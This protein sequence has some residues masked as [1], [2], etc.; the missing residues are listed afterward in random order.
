M[1]GTSP[2]AV[3]VALAALLAAESPAMDGV[4]IFTYTATA[5]DITTRDYLVLG[6][7]RGTDTPHGMGG[8]QLSTYTIECEGLVHL[9]GSDATADRAW[10]ILNTVADIAASQWTVSGT[11]ID[12]QMEDW[13]ITETVYPSGGRQAGYTFTIR[14]RDE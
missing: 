9:S 13:E 12:A 6:D 3:K 4:T 10:A 8:S 7:V 5:D 14:V 11:V 1:A 2:R